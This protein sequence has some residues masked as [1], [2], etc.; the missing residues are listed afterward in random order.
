[1]PGPIK[2]HGPH[3]NP[4][5]GLRI[6]SGPEAGYEGIHSYTWA[7]ET[8]QVGYELLVG[9]PVQLSSRFWRPEIAWQWRICHEELKSFHRPSASPLFQDRLSKH[10]RAL[11]FRMVLS[12]MKLACR[13][14][15]I[16]NQ[17]YRDQ[18]LLSINHHCDRCEPL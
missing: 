12:T 10:S 16:V 7:I 11:Y 6:F 2:Q 4:G 9:T 5:F 17:H 1:M 13:Y 15:S 14:V 18:P 3:L 8:F